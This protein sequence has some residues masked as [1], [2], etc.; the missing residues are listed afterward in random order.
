[1]EKS[2]FIFFLLLLTGVFGEEAIT[3]EQRVKRGTA[4]IVFEII[5]KFVLFPIFL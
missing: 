4:E 5:L 2:F 1:V 3:E